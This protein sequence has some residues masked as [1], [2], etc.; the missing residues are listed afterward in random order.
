M[1]EESDETELIVNGK[2]IHCPICDHNKFWS[3]ETLMN[4][5]G[6][7]FFQLEWANR[8]AVN[9]ICGS[10]GYVMWFFHK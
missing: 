9:H 6:A 3:R 1:N 8:A 10:C 4:S 5:R 2:R 7:T